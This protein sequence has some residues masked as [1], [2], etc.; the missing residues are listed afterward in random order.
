MDI[1]EIRARMKERHYNQ[2]DLANLLG[3]DPTAVSKRLTGKRAFRHSEMMKVEAW[4]GYEGGE[5]ELPSASIRMIPI[6]GMVAAGS[7]K[8][9]VEQ[10]LGEMP[11]PGSTPA[12]AVALQVDGDSMDLEIEHGGTVIVD[13][14]D[15]ALFPGRLYVIINGEGETTFK[16]FENEPARLVPRSTNPSHTPIVIGDGTTFKVY[17]RVTALHRHR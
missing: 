9:A 17:G 3:I 15:K 2:G 13:R 7:S 11:V 10:K 8:E 12:G 16:Q 5:P 14:D 4:L 1:E 6:I